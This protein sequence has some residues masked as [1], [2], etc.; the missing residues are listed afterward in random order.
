MPYHLGIKPSLCAVALYV[1]VV[2]YPAIHTLGLGDLRDAICMAIA[3]LPCP[4]FLTLLAFQQHQSAY[5]SVGQFA[6][7]GY[8]NWTMS[9][10][11]FADM[12]GILVQPQSSEPFSVT[13][14]MPHYLVTN[15]YVDQ[16]HLCAEGYRCKCRNQ[17]DAWER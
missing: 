13:A 14:E 4:D 10:A 17:I 3:A 6:S 8:D 15:E 1:K 11:F 2:L 12:G 7:A 16:P 5:R 9:H